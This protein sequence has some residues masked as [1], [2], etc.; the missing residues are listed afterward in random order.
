M[1]VVARWHKGV[2]VNT[3]FVGSILIQG[4]ELI[5]FLRSGNGTKRG[6]SIHDAPNVLQIERKVANGVS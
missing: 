4:N 2:T 5:L 1:A 3:T 6:V